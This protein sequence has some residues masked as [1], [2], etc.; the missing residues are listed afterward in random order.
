MRTTKSLLYSFD[1]YRSLMPPLPSLSFSFMTMTPSLTS[2]RL[3]GVSVLPSSDSLGIDLYIQPVRS[4]PLNRLVKPDSGLN[5]SAARPCSA[6]TAN[7]AA[8]SATPSTRTH[9]RFMRGP[10]LY[11]EQRTENRGQRLEV[12]GQ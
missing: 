4:L 3:S 5:S 9:A 6:A 11:R 1:V 8:S 2:T 12:S 10:P 7:A